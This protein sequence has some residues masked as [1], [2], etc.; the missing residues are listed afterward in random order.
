[1][2]ANES[3][4]I[5]IYIYDKL[6]MVVMCDVMINWIKKIIGLSGPVNPAS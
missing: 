2:L 1:M 5:Y 6:G 4:N 3:I